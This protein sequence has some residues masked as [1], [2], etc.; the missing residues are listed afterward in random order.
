MGE[1]AGFFC[2]ECLLYFRTAPAGV[3]AVPCPRCGRPV[4]DEGSGI[5]PA[6]ALVA[7]PPARRTAFEAATASAVVLRAVDGSGGSSS[8][9]RR[10]YSPS[11]HPDRIGPYLIEGEIG[12]GGMGIVYRA[13]ARD[14]GPTVALKRMREGPSARPADRERFLRE[15]RLAGRLRHAGIVPVLDAGEDGPEFYFVMPLVPGTGL[16]ERLLGGPLPPVDAAGLVAAV[17][18]AVGHAHQRGVVHRDLKPAN[19]LLDPEHGPR[20]TDFGLARPSDA[21]RRLTEA[22]ELFG[23][24]SYMAPE[25]LR[26][27]A[28]APASDLYALGAI[29]YECLTGG[30]P[31]GSGSFVDL[32]ARSLNNDPLSP[33]RF[34]PE[35]PPALE[36]ICL[37]ALA[38]RP[39][40][41]YAD[42]EAFAEDL[43]RFARG[44]AV[45]ARPPGLATRAGRRL[46]RSPVAAATAAALGVA[47]IA[48]LLAVATSG[49][50]GG[51]PPAPGARLVIRADPPGAAVLL[52]H[53]DGEALPVPVRLGAAPL[54]GADVPAGGLRLRLEAPG[55]A[56]VDLP[57]ALAPGATAVRELRLPLAG[58]VPPGM[59]VIVPVPSRGGAGGIPSR[60]F[61]VDRCEVTNDAYKRFCDAT[62]ART[63]RHWKQRRIPIGRE[64][65]PVVNVTA[66]EAEAYAAWAGNRLP[67]ALEWQA[68]AQGPD[69]RRFPWGDV[70]D[71]AR[72]NAEEHGVGGTLPVGRLA[73]GESPHGVLDLAGNAAEWTATPHPLDPAMRLVAG[74]HYDSPAA[75]CAATALK[76]RPAAEPAM[77]VGF[78]CARDLN[79]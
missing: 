65:H 18:R 46:R 25:A 40:D 51:A 62:G 28:A 30:P 41:R 53:R 79:E 56:P 74:G 3:T 68:V 71:P 21:S 1:P 55:R 35:I 34:R 31:H 43:E 8:R 60:P 10:P 11:R 72:A 32:A 9:I 39:Q 76:P 12:R 6:V 14:G 38:R 15:A 45:K 44:E 13:R 66:G 67:T 42:A 58:D 52:T 70:F 29:L 57:L 7:G 64:D 61:L 33:R 75:E 73:A 69:A 2:G 59:V 19:I 49:G 77:T 78:R 37:T 4:G 36:A 22:G 26:G 48:A 20:V 27:G 16:D 47:G 23:T 63:P 50:R 17:A 24:P 54:D 5:R